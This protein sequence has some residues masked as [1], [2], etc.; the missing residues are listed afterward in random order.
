MPGHQRPDGPE[1]S[2]AAAVE[3]A[4]DALLSVWDDVR[5]SAP[6]RLSGSQLRALLVIEQNEGIN[7][8]G[9]A[10]ELGAI[11][12]SASRLCDRLVA[13][14]LLEREPGRLDRRE[15][16]L[17]LTPVSRTLLADLRGERRARLAEVLSRMSQ[18]GRT[19]LLSG[20]QEFHAMAEAPAATA[21]ARSA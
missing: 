18:A 8:R 16:A 6:T 1:A 10:N 11:L 2:I 4:A 13:A 17:S 7:L 15:I 20:L 5:E 14:G 21:D 19:A 12:S 3:S 9:V